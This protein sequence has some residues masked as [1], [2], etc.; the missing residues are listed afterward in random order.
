LP[1]ISTNLLPRPLATG[2]TGWRRVTAS[3]PCRPGRTLHNLAESTH[4]TER[5][6]VL[7]YAFL[8][9]IAFGT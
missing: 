7:L 3:E 5:G 6:F 1:L 2:I 4:S 8:E 9:D